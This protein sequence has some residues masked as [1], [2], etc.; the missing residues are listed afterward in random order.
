M[1]SAP[2]RFSTLLAATPKFAELLAAQMASFKAIA[3]ES[4]PLVA[5]A[6][7][8]LSLGEI[9]EEW[10]IR[11][12][13]AAA[14][15][16]IRQNSDDSVLKAIDEAFESAVAPTWVGTTDHWKQLVERVTKMVETVTARDGRKLDP[17]KL[18]VD[19]HRASLVGANHPRLA[20]S[21]RKAFDERKQMC[22]ESLEVFFLSRNALVQMGADVG[23]R[24][25]AEK[26]LEDLLPIVARTW[27]MYEYDVPYYFASYWDLG[28]AVARIHV[29]PYIWNADVRDCPA[30]DYVHA[31]DPSHAFRMYEAG[32]ISLRAK[33]R[34][35]H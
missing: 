5:D 10:S 3:D 29:S 4:R 16:A 34:P 27:A 17:T 31:G 35:I 1:T 2:S 26:E 13:P 19:H 21:L 22:W 7:K 6:A 9:D 28:S 24:E 25:T 12:V 18:F 30:T 11:I 33:S 20:A 32:L 14:Q 15:L 23:L 8:R